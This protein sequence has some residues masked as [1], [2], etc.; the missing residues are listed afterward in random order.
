[1][2]EG[3]ASN[4]D[5]Y[6]IGAYATYFDD[7]GVYV[8]SVLKLNRFN[9]ALN[10]RMTNGHSVQADCHWCGTG[11]GLPLQWGPQ[12]FAE[13]YLLTSFFSADTKDV[14]LNNGKP[15]SIITAR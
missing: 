14:K 6:S 5:S 11:N 1:M 12:W 13:P 10:A 15:T 8:D 7:S 4:T 2:P 9:H 3:G